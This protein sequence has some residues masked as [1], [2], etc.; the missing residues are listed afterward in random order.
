MNNLMNLLIMFH[1]IHRLKREG[2][3]DAWISRH[4]VLNRRTV[5][6]YLHMSEEEYLSFKD[7]GRPRNK[8]LTRY[9]D[10][11]RTRLE[12][13]P[14]ASAAQVHDW[15]KEHFENFIE[16]NEKTVFNYVLTIRN[17]YDIPKL[18]HYRD[19]GKVEELPFGK[20]AQADFGEYH[21]T[22][23]EGTRKKVYFFAMVLSASRQKYVVYRDS[24]FTAWAMI[25][26]HEQCFVFFMGIVEQV[27]YDQD[28]LMLVSENHG[29][30]LLTYEFRSYVTYRG[31]SLHF[32]RKAD[33]QSKGKVENVIRYIKYNFLRG[34]KYI[35]TPVLNQQSGQWLS[36]TANAKIHAAT[37]KIPQ[38][39]WEQEKAF[40]KPLEGPYHA[41]QGHQWYN[42]R[43]DN[44]IAYKGNFYCLPKGTYARPQTRVI[45][46]IMDDYL[47]LSDANQNEIAR[48][49]LASGKGKHIGNNN[50]NRDYSLKID[51]LMDH[52]ADDYADPFIARE[53]LN[54]IRK[55]NPR[56]IRDQL[57][58]IKRQVQTYGIKIMEQ[59][60]SFCIQNKIFKATDMESVAKKLQAEISNKTPERPPSIQVKSLSKSAFKITP[61]KSSISD[62]KNLM[63]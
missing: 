47:V 61:E 42:V 13:C 9:E 58:L 1:E 26:A 6:K 56:Y 3:S 60:L 45:V 15:L 49:N 27:V 14:D 33:P 2:F 62:Y 23:G 41:E 35:S 39:Q 20:Q 55:D 46:K 48:Y 51:K 54:Q 29:D 25:D 34:R 53:Y 24:P 31:F 18:F 63:N 30:L 4:L 17:N 44:T 28:K 43:K 11:I 22:T 7:S 32:C 10:F 36:R 12:E 37:R 8:L 59:T 40:L 19:F 57:T 50:Y 52:V 38:E 5:T 21:M 16:V